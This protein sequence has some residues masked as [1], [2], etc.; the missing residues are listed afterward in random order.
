M[1][2]KHLRVFTLLSFLRYAPSVLAWNQNMD[3]SYII[4]PFHPTRAARSSA[5]VVPLE[6]GECLTAWATPTPSP[7]QVEPHLL[8]EQNPSVLAV[9]MYHYTGLRIWICLWD[10]RSGNWYHNFCL[11]RL[12]SFS[13]LFSLPNCHCV[14]LCA[15]SH[16]CLNLP[17][18]FVRNQQK[19]TFITKKKKK[20][21]KILLSPTNNEEGTMHL[22]AF[23]QL[24]QQR[25]IEII[26]MMFHKWQKFLY[27]G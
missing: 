3:E 19:S 16:A 13:P 4:Q 14:V 1:Q 5:Q 2:N 15:N 26:S 18:S 24:T 7:S 17:F 27:L 10:D 6:S 23:A 22:S 8:E 11:S 25:V 12:F 9:L 20:K 21:R